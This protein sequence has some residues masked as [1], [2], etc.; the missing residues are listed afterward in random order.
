MTRASFKESPT[1]KQRLAGDGRQ[2]ST[3]DCLY[4]ELNSIRFQQRT[5]EAEGQRK[6]A[7]SRL[8]HPLSNW[9]KSSLCLSRTIADQGEGQ[10]H[11]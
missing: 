11:H 1:Y 8:P 10:S 7:C 2:T 6:Y 3:R 5:T 4:Y 9:P